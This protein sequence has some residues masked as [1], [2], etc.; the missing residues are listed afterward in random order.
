MKSVLIEKVKCELDCIECDCVVIWINLRDLNIV[1][2]SED[3]LFKFIEDVIVEIVFLGF[4][5]ICLDVVSSKLCIFIVI[6][7]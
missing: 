2:L 3:F 1:I 5:L 4:W 7:Y 6:Y